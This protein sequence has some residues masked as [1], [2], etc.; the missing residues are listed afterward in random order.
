[1]HAVQM[2]KK[3][4][5]AHDKNYISTAMIQTIVAGLPVAIL[6]FLFRRHHRRRRRRP[7]RR[8]QNLKHYHLGT[9]HAGHLR[10]KK[11]TVDSL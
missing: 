11:I 10:V 2:I 3:N 7:P 4:Q 6:Y 9:N 5:R 8:R 1:M